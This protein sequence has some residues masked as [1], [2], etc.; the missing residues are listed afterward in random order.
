NGTVF[1]ITPSGIFKSLHSFSGAGQGGIPSAGLTLG[2]DGALYGVTYGG[3]T[4]GSGTIFKITASGTF[5]K[6]SD[7]APSSGSLLLAADGN[8]YGTTV[9]GGDSGSGS[10]F[11]LTPAGVVPVLHSFDAIDG[12]TPEAGL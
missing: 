12:A 6:L 2:S 8:M 10:A 9:A 1:S 3:G 7:V 11:K 5:T 4:N